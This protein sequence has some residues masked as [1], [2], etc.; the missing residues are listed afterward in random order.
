MTF[1]LARRADRFRA[2]E[3]VLREGGPAD[4]AGIVDGVL[5]C[6]AWSDLVVPA[7]LRDGWQPV[8]DDHVG[9]PPAAAS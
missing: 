5:L 8:I 6:E 7:E 3:I 1:D 2:Y 4:I 9:R